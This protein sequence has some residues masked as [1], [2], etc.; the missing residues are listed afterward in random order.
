MTPA[1]HAEE[2]R[3]EIDDSELHVIEGLRHFSNV[4]APDEFNALLRA[5]LDTFATV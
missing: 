2:I 3:D 4:E 1:A 5:G